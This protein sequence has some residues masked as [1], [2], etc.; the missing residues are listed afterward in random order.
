MGSS[1]TGGPAEGLNLHLLRF[2]KQQDQPVMSVDIEAKLGIGHGDLIRD[3]ELLAREGYEIEF[4]PY[5]GVRLLDIPDRLL[6]H[7]INEG[8]NTKVVGTKL[9]IFESCTSTSDEA[10]LA[11]KTAADGELFLAEHQTAGRGRMGRTWESAKGLGLYGSFIVKLKLEAGKA[12]YLTSSIALSFANTIEQFVHL[13]AEIKWPNDVLIGGRKVAG[14]LVESRSGFPDTFVVGFGLNVN[15]TVRDFGALDGVATS[16]RI[17][18]RGGPINRI[19]LLRPLI[20]Y[21]DS[22]YSQLRKRKFERIAK[23]WLEYVDTRKRA[24][25]VKAAQEEIHGT[26]TGIDL[27]KGVSVEVNGQV[28]T[29][30]PEHVQS[31]SN[32]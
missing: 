21:L 5:L 29:F 6:A 3:L 28:R 19:R 15:H 12:P 10:W 2:L 17:E 31:V 26:L 14:I 22:V 1:G 18:R 13:P 16:L 32:A 9:H 25:V 4:H 23:A 20:F 30:K 11:A 27:D 7:E 8:L 24:V